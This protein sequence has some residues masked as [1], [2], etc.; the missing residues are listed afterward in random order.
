MAY[1][2]HGSAM[3]RRQ[4][5]NLLFSKTASS[6]FAPNISTAIDERA[7]AQGDCTPSWHVVQAC[8]QACKQVMM[9]NA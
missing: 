6:A 4:K 2:G 1:L 9:E 8:M 3:M 5:P 7:I